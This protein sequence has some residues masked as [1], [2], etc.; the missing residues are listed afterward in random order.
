MYFFPSLLQITLQG[1]F[2]ERFGGDSLSFVCLG[3]EKKGCFW[4]SLWH[5]LWLFMK[6][7]FYSTTLPFC[8]LYVL[9]TTFAE[10][11]PKR[12]CL[13]ARVMS[14]GIKVVW[15]ICLVNLGQSD[16][17]LSFECIYL[18]RRRKKSVGHQINPKILWNPRWSSG[19]LLRLGFFGLRSRLRVYKCKTGSMPSLVNF[20]A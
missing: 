3:A 20:W 13:L 10:M 11:W 17:S 12:N 19:G 4:R 15:L 5:P 9:L 7:T 16:L 18:Y 8:W 1:I 6:D 14:L 2:A